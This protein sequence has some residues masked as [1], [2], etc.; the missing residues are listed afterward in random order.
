MRTLVS[1]PE[2]EANVDL[3]QR[4]AS[5]LANDPALHGAYLNVDSV[6]GEVRISG[7]VDNYAQATEVRRV[8]EGVVGTGRVMTSLAPR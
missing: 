7:R 4:F 1:S 3:A 6:G 8:A 2:F 5:M